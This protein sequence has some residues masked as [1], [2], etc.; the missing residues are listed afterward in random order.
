MVLYYFQAQNGSDDE[1]VTEPAFRI[2]PRTG[3]VTTRTALDRETVESYV[4]SV[5]ASDQAPL[6]ERRSSTATLRVRV[7]DDNDNYPQFTE[8]T[9]SVLVP[10]DVDYTQNPVIGAVKA[11][12]ADQGTNAAV[13][14]AIIGGNTQVR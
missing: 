5:I 2:D 13:R 8:R 12:D 1:Q 14:Y 9:Y 11:V 7:L 3:V 6:P 10:E 4:L